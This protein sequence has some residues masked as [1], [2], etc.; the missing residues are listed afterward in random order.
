MN[1]KL[2][3]EINSRIDA[4]TASHAAEVKQ[5]EDAIQKCKADQVTT[6]AAIEAASDALDVEAHQ[7]A[8]MELSKLRTLEQMYLSR[9]GKIQSKRAVTEEESDMVIRELLQHEKDIAEEYRAA[10]APK[11]SE[12]KAITEKYR[13]EVERAEDTI[14]R[15]TRDIHPNYHNF[16]AVYIDQETGGRTDRNGKPHPVH[17]T[18]YRGCAESERVT[19]FIS[20]YPEMLPEE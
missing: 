1:K 20:R 16:G 4:L 11:L 9:L 6:T 12:L 3:S 2:L 5:I 18:P 8:T 19:D 10:I 15:W 13:R 7:A 14:T 17:L